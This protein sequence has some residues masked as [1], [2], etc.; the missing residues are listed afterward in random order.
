MDK[1]CE[2]LTRP[3]L[4]EEPERKRKISSNEW[5]NIRK[6]LWKSASPGDYLEIVDILNK[7]ARIKGIKNR[8]KRR[9]TNTNGYNTIIGAYEC[10][11]TIRK[12]QCR[13]KVTRK[14]K[15]SRK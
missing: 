11:Q 8:N 9:V 13:V 14:S 10:T 15:W 2:I 7:K 12:G 4:I 3:L 5:N 6:Q 1:I